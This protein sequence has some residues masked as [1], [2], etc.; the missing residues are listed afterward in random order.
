MCFIIV[1]IR[2]LFVIVIYLILSYLSGFKGKT[3]RFILFVF[4]LNER[5]WMFDG[6]TKW[7]VRETF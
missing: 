7:G 3:T 6:L 2:I 1:I 4:I 5:K